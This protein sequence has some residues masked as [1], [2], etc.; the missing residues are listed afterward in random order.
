LPHRSEA[1]TQHASG[2]PRLIPRINRSTRCPSADTGPASEREVPTS[3]ARHARCR[4]ERAMALTKTEL[5]ELREL[6][7]ATHAELVDRV[8]RSIVAGTRVDDRTFPDSMDVSDARAGRGRAH[9]PREPS[10]NYRRGDRSR[11][12]QVRRG[13][14]RRRRVEPASDSGR[15]S[16]SHYLGPVHEVWIDETE[17]RAWFLYESSARPAPPRLGRKVTAVSSEVVAREERRRW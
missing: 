17:R 12:R 8:D 15:T 1:S 6:L 2:E 7:E 16:A 9:R 14:V 10:A 13:F 5:K 3:R 4:L 11:A